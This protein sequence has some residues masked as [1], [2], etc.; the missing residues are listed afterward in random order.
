MRCTASIS[1]EFSA[2]YSHSSGS[3]AGAPCRGSDCCSLSSI[4]GSHCKCAHAMWLR[5]SLRKKRGFESRQRR[6]EDLSVAGVGCEAERKFI[7]CISWFGGKAAGRVSPAARTG[8]ATG[9]TKRRQSG[10]LTRCFA[11]SAQLPVDCSESL[12]RCQVKFAKAAKR[13]RPSCRSISNAAFRSNCHLLDTSLQLMFGVRS[14]RGAMSMSNSSS[15]FQR[16][17]AAALPAD[18]THEYPLEPK[19]I[20]QE[21]GKS[22]AGFGPEGSTVSS[23]GFLRAEEETKKKKKK[24]KKRESEPGSCWAPVPR[25]PK[26]K[27]SCLHARVTNG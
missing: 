11:L 3:T 27:E 1:K 22:H 10:N 16:Q 13:S 12:S 14:A 7:E 6:L 26:G 18:T 25:R 4:C 2:E 15:S 23:Q 9:S 17:P 19:T 24:K 8:F 21:S 20:P 5:P